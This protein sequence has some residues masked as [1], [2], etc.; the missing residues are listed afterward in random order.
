MASTPP[1]SPPSRTTRVSLL[2][3]LQMIWDDVGESDSDREKYDSSTGAK[4]C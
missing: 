4:L 2:H 3:Q 1:S